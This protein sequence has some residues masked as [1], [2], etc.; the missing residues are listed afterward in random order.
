MAASSLEHLS[1]LMNQQIA[2]QENLTHTLAQATALLDV[3]LAGDFLNHPLYTV[4]HYLSVLGD[5][6][7]EVSGLSEHTLN[8]LLKCQKLCPV[9]IESAGSA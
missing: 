4:H 2:V 5:L 1:H 8:S 3:A 7:E 6:V 9:M